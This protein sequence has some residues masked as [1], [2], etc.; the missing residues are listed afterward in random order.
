[1]LSSCNVSGPVAVLDMMDTK[2]CSLTSYSAQQI[3]G[4]KLIVLDMIRRYIM[5]GSLRTQ[6]QYSRWNRAKEK[7]R[8]VRIWVFV[9]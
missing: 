8:R 9:Y 1:M 7:V 2:Q 3:L 4:G 5:Q 6:A